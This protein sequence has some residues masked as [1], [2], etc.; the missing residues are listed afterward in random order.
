MSVQMVVFDIAG[1]TMKDT[2]AIAIAF[3]NA[4]KKFGYEVPVAEINPLMGYKKPQ[5]IRVILE[6]KETDHSILS[7]ALIN[8]IHDQFLHEMIQYYKTADDLDALPYAEE[9][10]Q[11]F[12]DAGIKVILDTGFSHDITAIIMERLGWLQNGLVDMT[13]SSDEVAAGRPAPYMIQ[14][15]ME[16]FGIQD[17]KSVI[18]LGD[19]EVDV[20]EGKNADC[21]LSIAMTTGAFSRAELEPYKPD[22][23]LDDLSQLFPIIENL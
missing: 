2:G 14:K 10:F 15:A 3:Q 21:L 13:V 19:T 22:Y 8:E 9:T 12:H 23:I 4:M 20:N 6:K 5:A 17:P 18:K 16:A 1:T 11:K 7:E